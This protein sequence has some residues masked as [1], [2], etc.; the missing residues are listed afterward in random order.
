MPRDI[1]T[2]F[3]T[4]GTGFVGRRLVP[5]LVE[6]GWKVR[7]LVRDPA[8]AEPFSGLPVELVRGGLGRFEEMRDAV[9][10]ADAVLHLAA[11]TAARG[12]EEY[13]RVNTAFAH[14]LGRAA[15]A[16]AVPPKAFVFVSSLAALGPRT[17]EGSGEDEP[18]GLIR[19]TDTPCPVTHYGVSKLAGERALLGLQGLPLV[20]LRPPAV[21]GPGDPELLPLFRL[22]ARGVFPL[23]NRGARISLVH[24]D[25][26]VRAIA[27]GAERG[28]AGESYHVAHGDPVAAEDL[29]RVLAR[30]LGRERLLAVPV[31]YGVLWGAA[32]LSELAGRL[33]GK[34]PVFN[35]QKARELAAPGWACATQ[36]AKRELGFTADIG[37][38]VGLAMTALWYRER[39]WL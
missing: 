37:L 23:A 24:V 6:R 15:L 9:S 10:G 33:R 34:A 28:R 17:G 21:Y 36:K 13:M 30:A 4:G 7:C 32:A 29:P 38:P 12:L 26:L 1:R 39:G 20:I 35:R 25:D 8:K 27:L 16:A 5:H 14:G 31:P 19:E 2:C 22:A 11:L 3:V 18:S